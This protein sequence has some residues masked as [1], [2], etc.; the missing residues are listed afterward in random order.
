M[1]NTCVHYGVYYASRA[2]KAEFHEAVLEHLTKIEIL[3][4]HISLATLRHAESN[5]SLSEEDEEPLQ[6][7]DY[8]LK[9][10]ETEKGGSREARGGS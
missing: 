7:L 8:K 10:S 4:S 6:I 2:T 9:I 1:E 5:S 3:P